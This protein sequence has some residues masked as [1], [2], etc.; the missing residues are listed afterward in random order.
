MDPTLPQR[1]NDAAA[2]FIRDRHLLGAFVGGLLRDA[3]AAE[4]VLQEVWLQLAAELEKGTVIQ[5]QPAWCRGVARNLIRRHWEKSQRGRSAREI[6]AMGEFLDRIDQ[7]FQLADAES[8]YATARIAAL[9]ECLETLP[10][11][12]RHLLSLKY[13]RGEAVESI[14]AEVGQSFETV[15]KALVRIRAGLHECVRQKL[16]REEWT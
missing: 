13:T 12:S 16:A 10:E 3:H 11:R 15:K 8:S 5:N 1:L 7:C 14:A 9:D 6:L 4:D 2:G